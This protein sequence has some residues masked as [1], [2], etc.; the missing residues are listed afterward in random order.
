MVKLALWLPKPPPAAGTTL[1]LRTDESALLLY[2]GTSWRID[3]SEM[4][5]VLATDARRRA[6]LTASGIRARHTTKHHRAALRQLRA[7]H[8]RRCR[9]R[10]ADA[11]RVYAAD[12]AAYAARLQA[13]VVEY[14]DLDQSAL[15]HFPWERLRRH[16]AAKLDERG[17]GFVHVSTYPDRKPSV[18]ADEGERATPSQP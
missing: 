10:I 8:Q 4:R 9:Q 12:A 17:I 14:S 1:R 13:G 7:D 3:A 16:I 2:E 11:C 5:A 18:E 15:P 6:E